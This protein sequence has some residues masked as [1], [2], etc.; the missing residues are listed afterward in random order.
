MRTAVGLND[1]EAFPGSC[2]Q[3]DTVSA[4]VDVDVDLN[5]AEYNLFKPVETA[6]F[7]AVRVAQGM[8]AGDV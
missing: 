5:P 6:G 2:S 7:S 8:F 4:S 3:H 1:L